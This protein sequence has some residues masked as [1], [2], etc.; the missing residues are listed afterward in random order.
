[1]S[2][3]VRVI[4][5]PAI[6]P[7]TVEDVKLHAHITHDVEN[8]IIAGWIRSARQ[9][10]EDFQRRSYI[11]QILEAS[12]DQFPQS[13]FQI[14]RPPLIQVMDMSYWDCYNNY[15]NLYHLD[16]NPVS[17]T[18]EVGTEPATNSHFIIDTNSQPGRIS[19]AY[20]ILWPIVVLRNIDSFRVRYAAGYGHTA[21]CIPQSV[22]DAIML[23]CT[24]R[25]ENRAA[26]DKEMPV[27]MRNLLASDRAPAC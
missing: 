20:M 7:V 15:F 26:E 19:L 14:P 4:V 10:A 18:E 2:Y 1:M 17:T 21:D 9:Q 11:S 8:S 16:W 12:W 27:Q 24:W 23:Y 25:N 5:P 22:K 13:P 3:S 6:E